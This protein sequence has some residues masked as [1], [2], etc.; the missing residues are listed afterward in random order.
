MRE[1]GEDQEMYKGFRMKLSTMEIILIG[2]L[3][4][5]LVLGLLQA[6]QHERALNTAARDASHHH[7]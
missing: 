7:H 1:A 2:F 4:G 5:S 3:L 6:R